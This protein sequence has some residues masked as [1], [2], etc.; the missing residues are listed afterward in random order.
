MGKLIKWFALLKLKGLCLLFLGAEVECLHLGAG[1]Q[2]HSDLT[3]DLR[4]GTKAESDST[5]CKS[6]G[7]SSLIWLLGV[8]SALCFEETIASEEHHP[9]ELPL[10]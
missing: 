4:R 7:T 8:V 10:Q 6:L 5:T 2:G 3:I 1:I 9:K